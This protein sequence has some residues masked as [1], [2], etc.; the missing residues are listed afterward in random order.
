MSL[1]AGSAEG[2]SPAG[3]STWANA[4]GLQRLRSTWGNVDG[5]EESCKPALRKPILVA[6]EE[7]ALPLL[8][9]KSP[10]LFPKPE[11]W[12]WG[13]SMKSNKLWAHSPLS[14]LS[15]QECREAK[16][17]FLKCSKYRGGL[18][19]MVRG[20]VRVASPGVLPSTHHQMETLT[21]QDWW[22]PCKPQSQEEGGQGN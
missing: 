14:G 7:D 13:S 19:G 22:H 10:E 17:A 12:K 16:S 21:L 18:H 6:Y 8:R 9:I 3:H 1:D 5:D 11:Y 15:P 4:A 2:T 20:R